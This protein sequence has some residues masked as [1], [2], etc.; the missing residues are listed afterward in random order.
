M[1]AELA[2][3]V[4]G[5][6]DLLLEWNKRVN[7]TGARNVG[8]VLGDHLPDS[9]ALS[10]FVPEGSAVVDVGSGG[11][12]PAVPLAILRADCH[13]TLVEPRA[14]R[15]AFLNTAVR[16]CGCKNATVV[17]AR[18]AECDSS[19]FAVATSR[20]TFP[21]A[22][23]LGLGPALLVPGGRLV[24]LTTTE[25]P[26]ESKG[27]RLVDSVQYRTSDNTMRWAGCYCST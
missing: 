1:T 16:V 25:G 20:A 12:L 10:R 26:S 7:L 5:F 22:E 24:L 8:E 15:V 27:L 18:L 13:V 9:F 4:S 3:R 6:I 19:C 11:G 23:W 2:D 17:R 21:P 14:K